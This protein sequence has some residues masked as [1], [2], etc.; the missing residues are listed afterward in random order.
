MY[1]KI[2][3]G[4]YW[5]YTSTTNR[6]ST[7]YSPNKNDWVGIN[8]GTSRPVSSVKIYFVEDSITQVPVNYQLEYWNGKSWLVIPIQQK[9]F[10]NALPNMTNTIRFPELEISKIRVQVTPQ[11]DK[12]VAISELEAW[13]P[14]KIDTAR[15]DVKEQPSVLSLGYKTQ[16]T[17]S[18]SFTSRFDQLNF[19]NDGLAN[20]T[21]RWTAFESP[22][23]TDW[24]QFDF[25]Q[26][27]KVN[28]AYLY[29]YSD[30]G[31]VQPPKAYTI[32]Y[33][34]GKAWQTVSN[35]DKKPKEAVQGLNIASFKEVTTSKIRLVFQHKKEK[36]FT[37]LY[38]IELFYS[39]DIVKK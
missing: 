19:I 3:D 26:R 25:K 21:Y 17:L 5:Y 4:Q 31:G 20:P 15:V 30:K 28:M 9:S 22:N 36:A 16:A 29:F 18:A 11:L 10:L 6:W 7:Q 33:C 23:A 27:Q 12:A 38:E 8:F 14:Y 2:N 13:G 24:V 39:A 1:L 34:N 32:E 35:L 37:G